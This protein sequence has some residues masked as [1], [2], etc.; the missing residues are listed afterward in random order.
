MRCV[1]LPAQRKAP[2]LYAVCGAVDGGVVTPDG[3]DK[4]VMASSTLEAQE[5][6]AETLKAVHADAD[7]A[8][9]AAFVAIGAVIR[10]LKSEGSDNAVAI[11][12]LGLDRSTLILVTS[13][14][15]EAVEPFRV[16]ME[17]IFEAIQSALKLKFRGAGARLF[18]TTVM[19]LPNLAQRSLKP[20]LRS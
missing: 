14:G 16:G 15:V 4:W 20:L 5:K 17:S 18:S 9:P 2:F 1:R 13:R 11:W 12:D 8:S 10:S 7:G 6:A 3:L 19:T